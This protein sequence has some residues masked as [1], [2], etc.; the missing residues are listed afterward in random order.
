[1]TRG[2]EYSLIFQLR[3]DFLLIFFAKLYTFIYNEEFCHIKSL[4]ILLPVP[5]PVDISFIRSGEITMLVQS[6]KWLVRH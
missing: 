1:M 5:G 6:L 2:M 4:R 3:P